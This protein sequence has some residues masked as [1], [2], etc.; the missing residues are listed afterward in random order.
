[1][2][3]AESGPSPPQLFL[4]IPEETEHLY[5]LPLGGAP[6]EVSGWEHFGTEHIYC[7]HACVSVCED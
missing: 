3:T 6:P 7:L 1:M 2:E 4:P 5:D